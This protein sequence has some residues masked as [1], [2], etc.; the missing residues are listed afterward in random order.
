MKTIILDTNFLLIPAQFN[1]D[2]FESI[3]ELMDE[4]YELCVID[5]IVDELHILTGKGSGKDKNAAK[6]GLALLEAKNIKVLKTEKNLNTD[7]MIV[8]TAKQPD[9]I[10]ATQDQGLKRDLKANNV[11]IIVLRQKKRVAFE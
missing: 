6:L 3:K 5:M 4:A 11:K 10:V 1:V 7:K 9:F 8:E 2:I